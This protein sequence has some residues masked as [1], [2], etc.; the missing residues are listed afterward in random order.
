MKKVRRL[1]P[2]H[3]FPFR[4]LAALSAILKIL[5]DFQSKFWM[6]CGAPGRVQGSS[7]KCHHFFARSSSVCNAGLQSS[8]Q[9]KTTKIMKPRRLFT[10][11]AQRT[12][13]LSNLIAM[14]LLPMG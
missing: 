6:P 2:L 1:A 11:V 8:G 14:N 10:D 9:T 4:T 3:R 13:T 5:D 12:A 7:R